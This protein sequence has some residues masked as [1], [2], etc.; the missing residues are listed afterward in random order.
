MNSIKKNRS[1]KNQMREVVKSDIVNTF[2]DFSEMI[3]GRLNVQVISDITTG[4][5]MKHL[6]VD[7]EKKIDTSKINITQSFSF[8]FSQPEDLNV[9][10]GIILTIEKPVRS[11]IYLHFWQ[12][13][14]I[15]RLFSIN[16]INSGNVT[17][18]KKFSAKSSNH[19][20]ANSI[21]INSS[22]QDLFLTD[23]FLVFNINTK[24]RI[25]KIKLKNMGLKKYETWEM[26]RY[27]S[28]LL[29]INNMVN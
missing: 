1:H 14:L 13:E 22:I 2:K 21:F 28:T 15:D 16:K 29:L 26:E 18:D 4:G 12:R 19:T 24:N 9:Q 27:Y 5:S 17:F 20:L 7:V 10:T 23:K 11:N 6:I 3:D 8:L 25:A